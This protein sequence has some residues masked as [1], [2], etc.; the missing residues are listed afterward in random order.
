[1]AGGIGKKKQFLR[2]AQDDKI[3]ERQEFGVTRAQSDESFLE[4]ASR[5]LK[6][7]DER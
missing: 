4:F 5:S 2:D 3:E 6:H 7:R 1:M